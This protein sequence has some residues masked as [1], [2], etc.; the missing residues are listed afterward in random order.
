MANLTLSIDD[1]LLKRARVRALEEDTSVNALVRDYLEGFAARGS[2]SS[3][4]EGFL[5]WAESVHASS[6]PGGR[7]WT[8]D[9]LHER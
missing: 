6:G 9:D 3:G 4:M 5:T 8:R 7:A 1:Q 2:H